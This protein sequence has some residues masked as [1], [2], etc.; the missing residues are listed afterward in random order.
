M[1]LVF[2]STFPVVIP[3][4]FMEDARTALRTSNAIAIGLLFFGG[5]SYGHHAGMRRWLMGLAM[6]VIGTLLV[7]MTIALGG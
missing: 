6:V 3:F 2:L 1:L 4:L 5:F 7:G